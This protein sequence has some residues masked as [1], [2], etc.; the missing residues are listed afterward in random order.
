MKKSLLKLTMAATMVMGVSAYLYAAV[1][2][3]PV[4]QNLFVYDTSFPNFTLSNCLEC[5]APG[6]TDVT[7]IN[8]P[9]ETRHHALLNT[10]PTPSCINATGTLPASLATGCHILVPNTPPL[11]GF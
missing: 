9:L 1:P 7:L 8:T 5:H 11:T 6:Q 2:P 4:N 10:V 3:P